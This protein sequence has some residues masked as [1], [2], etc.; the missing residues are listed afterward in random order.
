MNWHNARN[1]LVVF[2]AYF[3]ASW[4][5][6]FVSSG[7][8]AFG[9]GASGSGRI[10]EV[11]LALRSSL[12]R[13]AGAG[14]AAGLLWF[15]IGG[16]AA[17]RWA[18]VLGGLFVALGYFSRQNH[19]VIEP[20]VVSRAIDNVVYN[21]APAAACA[22][23]IWLL[24]RYAPDSELRDVVNNAERSK[25]RSTALFTA[26][27]VLV[28]IVGGVLGMRIAISADMKEMSGWMI[29]VMDSRQ[30][31]EVAFSQYRGASFDG[32]KSALDR[33]A[34][35]LE[36]LSPSSQPWKPGQAPLLDGQGLALEKLL[37]YGRVAVKAEASGRPEVASTYWEKAEREAQALNWEAPVRDRIRETIVRLDNSEPSNRES[38]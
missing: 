38:R 34:A 17:R 14:V 21:L 4:L 27:T 32:A 20:D 16:A 26:W 22:G 11:W 28:L 29:A 37:T 12:P 13:M 10:G 9:I 7:E 1:L 2:G 6:Y 15:S 33:Y 24:G 8:A 5:S 30:R 3:C 19:W 35:Y 25:V 23:A 31:A 36:P 18:W